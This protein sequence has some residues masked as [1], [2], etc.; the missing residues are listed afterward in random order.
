MPTY[1]HSQS[2][3]ITMFFFNAEVWNL[4]NIENH[5]FENGGKKIHQ[6]THDI[7][8]I[9]LNNGITYRGIRIF[10]KLTMELA[11]VKRDEN[12]CVCGCVYVCVW[13]GAFGINFEYRIDIC[14]FKCLI[15]VTV[16]TI[17]RQYTYTCIN[18]YIDRERR[19]KSI[20]KPMFRLS[21]CSVYTL[22]IWT[23]FRNVYFIP[24]SLVRLNC[25]RVQ[26]FTSRTFFLSR[27]LTE[28][29]QIPNQIMQPKGKEMFLN[30]SKI[31]SSAFICIWLK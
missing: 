8:P 18:K 12:I 5:L 2:R 15:C 26:N 28:N 9:Y 22:H 19:K 30:D 24:D 29:E 7:D 11:N 16:T 20:K 10:K 17:N 25:V 13:I 3:S 23:C 6:T 21:Q 14:I 1:I 31:L 4:H 27:L